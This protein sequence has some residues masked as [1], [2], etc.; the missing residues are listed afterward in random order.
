MCRYCIVV[1]S[2]AAW[3]QTGIPFCQVLYKKKAWPY[4]I[5]SNH[6]DKEI[7]PYF[8]LFW[9]ECRWHTKA[10]KEED[11]IKIYD[12]HKL[13]V[14]KNS[15]IRKYS[16]LQIFLS[17]EEKMEN[18]KFTPD[19]K[20]SQINKSFSQYHEKPATSPQFREVAEERKDI[21]LFPVLFKYQ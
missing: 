10:V 7:T 18:F 21:S 20:Y 5:N 19:R 12:V 13:Q 14:I 4:S 1:S 17:D 11:W 9:I 6:T 8:Y 3:K 15:E 16:F 2:L